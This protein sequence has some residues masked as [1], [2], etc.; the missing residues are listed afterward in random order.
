LAQQQ[1]P[2]KAAKKQQKSSREFMNASSAL[3]SQPSASGAPS[4]G[5]QPVA[6]PGDATRSADDTHA[7]QAWMY[8]SEGFAEDLEGR[9]SRFAALNIPQPKKRFSTAW[10][11]CIAAVVLSLGVVAVVGLS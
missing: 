3:P 11:V 10:V 7:S 6:T 1:H 4:A 2:S 5:A 8:R 9:S